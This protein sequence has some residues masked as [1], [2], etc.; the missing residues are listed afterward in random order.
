MFQ[1]KN[2]KLLRKLTLRNLKVNKTRNRVAI[3]AIV[4]TTVLFT[5]LFSIIASLNESFRQQSFRQ[6]GSS[7]HVGFKNVTKE[8]ADAIAMDKSVKQAGYRYYLGKVTGEV[9][10]KTRVEISYMDKNAAEG[11]FCMPEKG[12]LPSETTQNAIQTELSAKTELPEVAVDTKVLELLGIKPEIGATVPLTFE[13][14]D[15]T[16]VTQDFSLSGWWKYDAAS[17]ASMVLVSKSYCDNVFENRNLAEGNIAEDNITENNAIEDSTTEAEVWEVG[18]MFENASNLEDKAVELLERQGF[19]IEDSAKENF[20]SLEVNWAYDSEQVMNNIDFITVFAIVIVLLMIGVTGYLIIYN[21]FRISVTS[22]IRF[23][24]LLKTIGTTKKQI[25]KMIL[26]QAFCLSVVG[27]LIGVIFGF[28][29][30][31]VLTPVI[32]KSLS[33]ENAAVS[34]HPLLFVA[35]ILFSL[36]TVFISCLKPAGIAGKVSPIEAVRYTESSAISKKAKKGRNGAKLLHMAFA[37]VGRSKSKTGLVVASLVLSAMLFTFAFVFANGFDMDKF[38]RKSYTSDFI[39]GS[40]NYFN[41]N[42]EMEAKDA[43]ESEVMEAINEQEGITKSGKI[44]GMFEGAYAEYSMEQVK[45]YEQYFSMYAEKNENGLYSSMIDI[46]GMDELPLSKL[47]VLEGDIEKAKDVS[48]NYI[49]QVVMADDYD[50][51]ID[52][53]DIHEVGDE[54]TITYGSEYEIYDSRTGEKIEDMIP[55][56]YMEFREAEQWQ[57]T[58]TI[59]AKVILPNSISYRVYSGMQYILGAETFLRDSRQETVMLY[60]V[61]VEDEWKASM[62]KFLNHY[63]TTEKQFYDYESKESYKKE[64]KDFQKMFLIVGNALAFIVGLV[65]VL[66]FMNAILTGISARR[67]EFAVMQ[68]VGMTGKQLKKMLVYEGLI[69]TGIS[70]L[71]AVV[72]SLIMEPVLINALSNLIWFFTGNVTFLP[73]MILLPVYVIVGAV[74][75]MILY[76]SI[77]KTSVVER[78]RMVE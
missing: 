59:C 77:S 51:P 53:T 11:K 5:S 24:G 26:F 70:I 7:F 44:Y 64:F 66:N 39:V 49:I 13:L 50:N 54:V 34:I 38:I 16:S 67:R 15:G 36:I 28:L 72:I 30:G 37:N 25:R 57:K 41:R 17:N 23:Y 21:I 74:V 2:K 42:R 14:E 45:Q 76:K 27:I 8:Q 35:A 55:E 20:V 1:V 68:S 33:F 73:L 31:N 61:D 46:Y 78:L 10:N 52:S 48:G 32:M 22:D 19:Q 6:Q 29:I 71:M 43:V 18:V 9:F 65:G 3:L 75:P 63:T 47:K 12:T 69:Y 4:L 58:Y 56:E 40:A 62:E 60:M